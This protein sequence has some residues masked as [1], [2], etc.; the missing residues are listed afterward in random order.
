MD[1]WKEHTPPPFNRMPDSYSFLVKNAFLWRFTYEVTNPKLIH[2]PY[3][4]CV[5]MFIRGSVHQALDKYKPDLVVGWE[6]VGRRLLVVVGGCWSA[7]AAQ[8]WRSHQCS[9]SA[10]CYRPAT[11]TAANPALHKPTHVTRRDPDAQRL[12]AH[13]HKNQLVCTLSCPDDPLTTPLFPAPSGVRAPADAAHPHPRDARARAQGP[14]AAHQL[15]HRGHRLH[16][17]PQHL[18]LPGGHALLRAHRVLQAAGHGQRHGARAAH[19]ARWVTAAAGCACVGVS[20]R[21]LCA[22]EHDGGSGLWTPTSRSCIYTVEQ[23]LDSRSENGVEAMSGLPDRGGSRLRVPRTT[24]AGQ[25]L[26]AAWGPTSA[27]WRIGVGCDNEALHTDLT[28]P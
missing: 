8:P 25:P 26:H 9:C 13:G 11:G 21:E 10:V 22:V 24:G 2:V 5:G 6:L 23:G 28:V 4:S 14:D 19:N 1:L 20:W 18:V 7:S 17:L 3:L 27:G 16:H 12:Y 15:R